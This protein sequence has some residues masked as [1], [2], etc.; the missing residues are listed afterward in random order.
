MLDGCGNSEHQ[1]CD[2]E[3]PYKAA[4]DHH[5]RRHSCNVHHGIDSPCAI[6]AISALTNK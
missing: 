6:E 4:R 2:N 1:E 5:A 3:Q